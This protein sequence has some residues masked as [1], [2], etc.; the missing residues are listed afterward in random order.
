MM[1]ESSSAPGTLEM[2]IPNTQ[3]GRV[4]GRGGDT[5]NRLQDQSGCRIQVAPDAGLPTR[6]CTLTGNPEA[7]ARAKQLIIDIINDGM[8]RDGAP[9]SM[10]PQAGSAAGDVDGMKTVTMMIPSNKVGAIIGRSG[11][12][13]RMLQE[14]SGARLDMI[15]VVIIPLPLPFPALPCPALLCPLLPSSCLSP[16]GLA[17][18]GGITT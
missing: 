10:A 7:I 2:Q 11:E 12:T 5:I 8:S 4:I 13:I 18:L 9:I 17:G 6:P 3:V 15:Q 16:P 14:R 1:S